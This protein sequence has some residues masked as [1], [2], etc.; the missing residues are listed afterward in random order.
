MKI[1]IIK[2]FCRGIQKSFGIIAAENLYY[3]FYVNDTEA[4]ETFA[5]GDRVAF[6]PKQTA[7]GL[8]AFDLKITS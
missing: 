1:G 3:L 6:N 7:N 5:I 4:C 2:N 8:Q